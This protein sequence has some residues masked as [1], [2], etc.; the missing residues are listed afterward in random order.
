MAKIGRKPTDYELVEGGAGGGRSGGGS[1]S[2][3]GGGLSYKRGEAGKRPMSKEVLVDVAKGLSPAIVAGGGG[4]GMLT[5]GTVQGNRQNRR[6][7]AAERDKA[8]VRTE[9]MKRA[10]AKPKDESARHYKGMANST[11]Q[12]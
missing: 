2:G 1:I 10:A 9:T 8:V 12:K 4:I 5:L 7:E 6:A 11:K 3:G